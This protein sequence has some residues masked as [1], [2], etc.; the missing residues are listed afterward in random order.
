MIMGGGKWPKRLVMQCQDIYGNVGEDE[1]YAMWRA[2]LTTRL[3]TEKLCIGQ[4][5]GDRSALVSTVLLNA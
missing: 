3:F 2:T 1:V 4:T 5:N